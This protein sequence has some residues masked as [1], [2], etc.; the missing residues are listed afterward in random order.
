[1]KELEKRSIIL[2]PKLESD[3]FIDRAKK[4]ME[5]GKISIIF[6]VFKFI[7]NMVPHF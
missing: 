2:F 5:N 6:L 7:G 3:K 4:F 1:M